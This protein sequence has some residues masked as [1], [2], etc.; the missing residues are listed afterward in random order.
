[1]YATQ[2]LQPLL[3]NEFNISV[4]KASQF[5]AIIMLFLGIA[6]LIYGYILES[7]SAKKNALY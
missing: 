3:A 1:M 6:P 4:I 5:T 2:P 7:F